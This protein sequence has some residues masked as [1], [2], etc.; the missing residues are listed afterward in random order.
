MTLVHSP[1]PHPTYRLI[2]SQFPPIGVFDTVATAADLEAVLNLVGW[3]S[4]RLIQH[5]INRLPRSEWVYGRPNSSI[6][7]ASFLHIAPG[8]MRFNG[9]DLGAWYAAASERT[10]I[11]EVAHHLR[12]EVVATGKPSLTRRYRTYVARLAGDYLDIRGQQSTRADVYDPQSYA[13]S[14][15]LG[16]QVRSSGGNGIIYDSLRH[17]GG[18]CVVVHRPSNIKDVTQAKHLD[19]H[20]EAAVPTITV[21]VLTA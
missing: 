3:T 7:M 10:G 21:T 9:P 11:A 5:R 19:L 8:G 14:Q 12:R 13:A 4:D 18:V 15:T 17:Q 16:E 1:A 20:V 2:P 6:I